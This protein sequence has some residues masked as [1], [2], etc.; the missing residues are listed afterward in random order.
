MTSPIP[1]SWQTFSGTR[2][3]EA[4]VDP[5]SRVVRR[6]EAGVELVDVPS[7]PL[8]DRVALIRQIVGQHRQGG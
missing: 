5:E 3:R 7:G 6:V 8:A 4:D 1:A 2:V